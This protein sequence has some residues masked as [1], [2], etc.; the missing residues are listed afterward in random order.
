MK[1][2]VADAVRLFIWPP[3]DLIVVETLKTPFDLRKE[4]FDQMMARASDKLLACVIHSTVF[5]A[6]PT[7]TPSRARQA[8]NA[9]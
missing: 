3:P 6:T 4:V 2:Q 1:H 7:E 8:D 9:S 5:S